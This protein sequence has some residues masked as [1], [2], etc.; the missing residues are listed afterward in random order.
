MEVLPISGDNDGLSTI[1]LCVVVVVMEDGRALV[2]DYHIGI[3]PRGLVLIT[4][5]QTD[6]GAA[7]S[8]TRTRHM[9]CCVMATVLGREG[10]PDRTSQLKFGARLLIEVPAPTETNHATCAIFSPGTL[11]HIYGTWQEAGTSVSRRIL[12]RD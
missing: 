11:S 9:M 12:H 1:S 7:T 3:Y 2:Q 10:C 4:A 6:R 8:V 5:Q